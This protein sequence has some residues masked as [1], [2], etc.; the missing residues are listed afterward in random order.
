MIFSSSKLISCNYR[1]QTQWS[2]MR[3]IFQFVELVLNLNIMIIKSHW[4][5]FEMCEC[6]CKVHLGICWRTEDEKETSRHYVIIIARAVCHGAV[7]FCITWYLTIAKHLCSA[8]KWIAIVL[9]VSSTVIICAYDYDTLC[10]LQRWH[11][12]W[13]PITWHAYVHT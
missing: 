13:K 2:E 1:C 4:Y 5:W 3:S 9:S 11:F 10:Q 12:S 6:V 7:S 8:N